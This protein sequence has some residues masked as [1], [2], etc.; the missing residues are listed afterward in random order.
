MT[1]TEWSGL[2]LA[3]LLKEIKVAE[4]KLSHTDQD[5]NP[6][7]EEVEEKNENPSCISR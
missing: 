6:E 2:R 5:L 1:S 4:L 7:N 3:L